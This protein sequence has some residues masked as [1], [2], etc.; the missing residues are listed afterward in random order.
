[1]KTCE[2]VLD[3]LPDALPWIRGEA[4]EIYDHLKVCLECSEAVEDTA[5]TAEIL[6]EHALEAPMPSGEFADR[7]MAA[8]PKEGVVVPFPARRTPNR[9]AMRAAAAVALFA[10]GLAAGGMTGEPESVTPPLAHTT[11][12]PA[13]EKTPDAV[14]AEPPQ[15]LVPVP[16]SK[17]AL[18]DDPLGDYAAEA[19]LVLQAVDSLETSDPEVLRLLSFHVQRTQLLKHGDRLLVSMSDDDAEGLEPL[20]SGTQLILRKVRHARAE[21]APQTLWTIREEVRRTGILDAYRQLLTATAATPTNTRDDP[22]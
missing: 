19:S 7:V 5:Q 17:A 6:R 4:L 8:L 20:I 21:S 2:D 13:A 18:S 1:M 15:Q 3:V 11:P 14:D 16:V 10:A 12:E 22:L 9:W